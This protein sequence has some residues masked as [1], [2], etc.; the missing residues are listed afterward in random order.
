MSIDAL[1]KLIF[2]CPLTRDAS[3]ET[4]LPQ[5]AD[6]SKATLAK[7]LCLIPGFFAGNGGIE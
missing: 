2:Y 3:R 1:E 4:I 5:C 7:L 6:L